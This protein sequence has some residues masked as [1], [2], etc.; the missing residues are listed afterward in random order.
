MYYALLVDAGD[1]VIVKIKL[2]VDFE[3]EQIGN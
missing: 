1:P 2:E 3:K